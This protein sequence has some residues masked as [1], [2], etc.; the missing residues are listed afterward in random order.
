MRITNNMITQQV[1]SNLQRNFGAVARLQDVL[2]TGRQFNIPEQNPIGYVESLNLRQE[3][4][5]NRRFSRNITLGTTSLQLTETTLGQVNDALQRARTLAL[6]ASNSTLPAESRI[7]IAQEIRQ[8]L[9]DIVTQANA[10]FEG[11]YLFAGDRTQRTPF[12]LIGD[13]EVIEAV[14]YRGDFGDRLIEI[15][16]D[17]FLPVNLTGPDAFFTSLNEITSSVAVVP[18]AL[19]EPQ[20]TGIV[21]PPVTLVAGDFTVD[22]VSIA[23]DPTTDTLENL[24]DA[25]NRSVTTADARIDENGRL[26]I[27]SLTS[28][29]V[30][31]ANGTS[32]VLEVLDLFHRVEGGAIGAGITGATTL[33]SLGITGDAI[34]ITTGEEIFDIDLGGATTVGD[35]ITSV[36]GS[37]APVEAFVNGAGT[38]ITFSATESVD[39]L[40]VTSLR[41]IFGSTALAPGTVTNDTTL[42]SLGITTGT[43][44]ITNDGA[45]T[46]V[47]LSAATTVEQVIS[48]IDTQVNGVNASI[49]ADG[50][51]I[52]IE[53]EFFSSSLSVADVGLS[54]IATTLGFAQTRS[55][56]NAADFDAAAPGTVNEVAS[57]N[58]FLTFSLLLQELQNASPNVGALNDILNRFDTDLVSISNNRSIVG[59]RINRLESTTDRYDAFEVFLTTLLS[60]NE[61]ADLAETVTQLSTQSNVLQASLAAGA[62]L[63]QPSLLDFLR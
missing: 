60:E 26:I 25:I 15:S 41:R 33:A 27:R 1:L 21:D 10:N 43:I 29:D 30:E 51:A 35:V 23:F 8:I 36:A 31:L 16:Q 2:S 44:S 6:Q 17:E 19:L 22:G 59:S 7:G 46:L 39:S 32:N 12:E 40:E 5:E 14:H 54:D 62:R 37:G 13:D 18:D 53:S 24:R 20:L 61:D 56:D 9:E 57:S 38:G 49:N 34:R 50:T 63:I 4:N 45:T 58:I 11:R 48:A 47:D 52:D 42:A 3:I 28:V 55:S